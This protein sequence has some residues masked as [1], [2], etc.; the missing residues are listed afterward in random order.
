MEPTTGFLFFYDR[1]QK[2]ADKME[3]SVTVVT[4]PAQKDGPLMRLSKAYDWEVFP[5]PYGIGGRFSVLFDSGTYCRCN[6]WNES[7]S[8]ACRCC[9]YG[10]SLPRQ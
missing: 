7:F 10:R 9:Q 1:C 2:H 6:S 5:V 4:D 8:V 3:L